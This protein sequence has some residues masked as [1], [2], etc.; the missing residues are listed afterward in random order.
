MYES[1]YQLHTDP[2]RL[3]PD[4]KFCFE[5]ERFRK[6][7][8]Y[9]KYALSQGDGV[10][11]ITGHP[12]TGKTMLV[13]YFLRELDRSTL[14]TANLLNTQVEEDDLFRMV[15]FGFGM[16]VRNLDRATILQDLQEFLV[17]KRRS[18]HRALLI[19]DEAQNLSPSA[20]EQLRML[21]N[22]RDKSRPLLQL[23]LIGQKQL[24]ELVHTPAMEP[25][26]QR[27]I[28][29]SH[30]EPLGLEETVAY[31]QH[32]LRCAGWRG[33]PHFTKAVRVLIYRFSGGYPRLINKICGR[34]LL[35]GS[36]GGKHRLDSKDFFS[37]LDQVQDEYLMPGNEIHGYTASTDL[38][39]IMHSRSDNADWKLHLTQEEKAFLEKREAPPKP[40]P[41]VAAAEPPDIAPAPAER[42]PAET[43]ATAV[44]T[45][46]EPPARREAQPDAVAATVK[47]K[48]AAR[49][50]APETSSSRPAYT[51]PH[52]PPKRPGRRENPWIGLAASVILLVSLFVIFG[53]DAN[54]Y[55][56]EEPESN[57]QMIASTETPKTDNTP[58]TSAEPPAV[59]DISTPHNLPT[60]S[61][62]TTPEA[63]NTAVAD[64]APGSE[65]PA[66]DSVDVA[67]V[68]AQY[69]DA[70]FATVSPETVS[71]ISV[72][73][74]A[75]PAPT[76]AITGASDEIVDDEEP[77]QVMEESNDPTMAGA[78]AL[79]VESEPEPETGSATPTEVITAA[80]EPVVVE[81][82]VEEPVVPK[83]AVTD[84]DSIQ[85][86]EKREI[87]RLLISAQ[88]AYRQDYLTTPGYKS[89]YRYFDKVLKQDP[90]NPAARR[91]MNQI[92]NR[93]KVLAETA[94]ERQ[95]YEMAQTLARRGLGIEPENKNLQ[96]LQAKAQ[97][98]QDETLA[99]QQAVTYPAESYEQIS[100]A[101]PDEGV[102]GKIRT[103]FNDLTPDEGSTNEFDSDESY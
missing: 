11:M 26:Y 41:V 28:A 19:V 35:Y 48:P 98:L 21:T 66:P 7:R 94:L 69:N 87:E 52:A 99:Q 24:N 103:F 83:P 65:A 102:F 42:T 2:F 92:V 20:L 96:V 63:K 73:D 4:P 81:P 25:L 23:F 51:R 47:E 67:Y 14:L 53:D 82:V 43:I 86:E 32:R 34:V 62:D 80:V 54:Y 71:S 40:E 77:V 75:M 33:D 93:Y 31:I 38:Q 58:Q 90:D 95:E 10:L 56:D 39:E 49:Y 1:S 12:G 68:D 6:G 79:S 18:G 100:G 57:R 84:P 85:K 55:Y 78:G 36:V 64:P 9:M 44:R 45:P 15:G 8:A 13:E 91:G 60:A 101:H 17:T 88:N 37:A 16:N 72:M 3:E 5:H 27:L 76:T 70:T 46:S 22:L 30:L 50:S 29:A 97:L 89:A 61:Q 59:N 74:E